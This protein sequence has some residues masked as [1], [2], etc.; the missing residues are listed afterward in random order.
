MSI[1]PLMFSYNRSTQKGSLGQVCTCNY[2]QKQVLPLQVRATGGSGLRMVWWDMVDTTVW[3]PSGIL[4]L[5]VL[6]T[7]RLNNDITGSIAARNM[8]SHA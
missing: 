5:Y 3:L 8:E 7:G 6:K 1:L 4:K 2:K